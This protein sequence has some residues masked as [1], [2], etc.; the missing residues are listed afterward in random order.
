MAAIGAASAMIGLAGPIFKGA[1]D[2][3]NRIK[4]VRM[5][6]SPHLLCVFGFRTLVVILFLQLAP[7]RAE[8]V[9]ALAE[10]ERDINLLKSLYDNNRALFEQHEVDADLKEL[11]Q[12]AWFLLPVCRWV[13]RRGGAESYATSINGWPRSI[14]T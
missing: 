5:V 4:L 1:R 14:Q 11:A 9:A 7:G 2:L 12:Y 6:Y 13:S 3:Q 10:Y 8:L